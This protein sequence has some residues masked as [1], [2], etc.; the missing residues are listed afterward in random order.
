MQQAVKSGR[1][2]CLLSAGVH[3]ALGVF[4]TLTTKPK[5]ANVLI[6]TSDVADKIIE[7]AEAQL[8]NLH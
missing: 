5:V 1:K 7:M 3:E 2:V 6:I 8:N 4:M